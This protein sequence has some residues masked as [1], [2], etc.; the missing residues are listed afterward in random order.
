MASQIGEV[1]L[2]PSWLKRDAEALSGGERQRLALAVAL[3][4]NPECLAMDEPTSALDPASA[5]QIADALS[6]RAAETGLRTIAVTHH[7]G[8]APLLGD[9]VVVLDR[10]KVVAEGAVAEVLGR[11]LEATR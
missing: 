3:G 6:N 8:H 9:R 1:G 4:T 7:R 2:D 11:E 5:R 10:G